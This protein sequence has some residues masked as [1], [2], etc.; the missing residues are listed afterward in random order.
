VQ[1]A[2][3]AWVKPGHDDPEET[4]SSDI[5]IFGYGSLMWDPGFAYEE[6]QP[7]LVRGWHRAFCVISHHYRGT[8][9]KPGLVLGLARGG[10]CRGRAFRVAAARAEA[11]LA[12]L[13]EREMVHYVYV[14]REV[15]AELPDGR[16]VLAKTYVAD[17][18]HDRYCGALP[19]DQTAAMIAEA[20]G[21]SGTNVDYL[22]NTIRHLDALGIREGAL[23]RVLE[24]VR[25][26]T[27]SPSRR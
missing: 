11:T 16:R 26:K 23:H 1:A 21:I 24:A 22:E 14:F 6:A 17:T 13:H 27:A 9:E 10:A 7:A 19:L 18:A 8:K 20:R 5:W 25:E 3:D 2:R 15:K 4:V 12:Y